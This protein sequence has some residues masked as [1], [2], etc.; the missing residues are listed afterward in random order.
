MTPDWLGLAVEKDMSLAFAT[1]AQLLERI[2]RER[3]DGHMPFRLTVLCFPNGKDTMLEVDVSP[4]RSPLLRRSYTG[5]YRDGKGR[6]VVRII[7]LD[8]L[9]ECAFFIKGE[10]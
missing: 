4:V 9:N 5:V 1:L 7:A 10:K 6:Q 3:I 2:E 8:N